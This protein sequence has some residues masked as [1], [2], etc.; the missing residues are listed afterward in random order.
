VTAGRGARPAY[1]VLADA[2]RTRIITGELKQGQRLPIEPD[3]STQY[4]VS[5]STVREALRVLASQNLITTHRGV[6]GG[7][8]VAYPNPEQVSGY[9]EAS[10]RLLTQSANL[11]IGQIAEARDMLEVPAAG[12]AAQR[13]SEEQ[14]QDL[15]S[16]LFDR[17]STSLEQAIEASKSFH[18]AL[19]R[20]TGSPIVEMLSRPVFEVVYDHVQDWEAPAGFWARIAGDHEAIFEAVAAQDP[21]GAREAIRD[22]LRKLRPACA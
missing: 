16:A 6:A 9:L 17:T 14:L 8:F 10:L 5:R 19:V 1:Q 11:T 18:A 2:L 4:G 13:R 12:L 20:A 15:K 22:H 3:L 7:S 21:N